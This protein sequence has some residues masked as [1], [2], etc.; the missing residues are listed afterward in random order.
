VT[1]SNPRPAAAASIA[2]DDGLAPALAHA[3]GLDV[4]AVTASRDGDGVLCLDV[5][6]AVWTAAATFLRDSCGLDFFDWLS[7]V[8]VPDGDPAGADVVLHVADSRSTRGH[9]GVPEGQ[10]P[11]V[12]RALLRTRVA[13]GVRPASVTGV[14][15][16]A[17]W[18]ERETYEMFGVTFD[19]F[20]DGS[21]LPLRKLLLTDEFEGT[22]LRKSFVL[23]ARAGKPWP[24]AKEPG[25]SGDA[26]AA[27]SRRKTLPPG[28]PEPETWA[29]PTGS[30]KPEPAPAG[31]GPAGRGARGDRP[32]RAPRVPR[33]PR[34]PRPSP[35]PDGGAQ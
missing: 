30:P 12:R 27:P 7:A 4:D 21:G 34:A 28:V 24:G 10:S 11:R 33:E 17:A 20:D 5:P 25:E 22:P 35:E 31:A 23:A 6:L 14:W 1:D 32:A 13:N 2:L 3:V 16:G 29:R 26:H 8:D 15:P 18:H 19:G 9:G